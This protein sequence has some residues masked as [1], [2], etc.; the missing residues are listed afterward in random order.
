MVRGPVFVC[1][2]VAHPTTDEED[3]DLSKRYFDPIRFMM[4]PMR[5]RDDA[6]K[7]AYFDP[8]LFAKRYFDPIIYRHPM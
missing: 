5:N 8:I 4:R 1:L 6:E 3:L 2:S 7:R